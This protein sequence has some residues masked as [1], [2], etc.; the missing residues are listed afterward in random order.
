MFVNAVIQQNGARVK[1]WQRSFTFLDVYKCGL[2]VSSE[3][4]TFYSAQEGKQLK[5]VLGS[6]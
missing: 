6:P 2:T 3:I 1:E 4:E 5:I